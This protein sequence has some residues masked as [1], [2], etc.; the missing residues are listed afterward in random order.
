MRK[1]VY[2]A[3]TGGTIGMNRTRQG[4]GPQVGYLQ[5]QMHAMPEL[6]HP[7]IPEFTIHDY[8]PLLDSSNMTP[9]EWIDIAQDIAKHHDEFDGFIVLHGTDTMAYTASALPFM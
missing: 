1:R 9:D 8:E 3:H 4:Y 2:I 6:E 7:S 5:Q